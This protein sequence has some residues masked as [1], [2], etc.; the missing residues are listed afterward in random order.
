MQRWHSIEGG[1]NRVLTDMLQ[2]GRWP[3]RRVAW[4]GTV[5]VDRPGVLDGQASSTV[6]N[7]VQKY[8]FAAMSSIL[9]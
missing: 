4:R 2:C 9:G 7:A 8:P 1:W 5:P 3:V 6:G